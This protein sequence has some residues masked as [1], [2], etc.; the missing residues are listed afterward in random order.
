MSYD[1]FLKP[2][3]GHFDWAQFIKALQARRHYVVEDS[4]AFYQN[5]DT[6]VYYCFEHRG[7]G[8]EYPL[9]FNLNFF[10]PSIFALEAAPELTALVERFD[11]VVEDPQTKGMGTGEYDEEKMLAGWNYG[12]EF[13]CRTIPERSKLANF[14]AIAMPREKILRFWNWNLHRTAWQDEEPDRYVALAMFAVINDAPASFVV[15]PDAIPSIFPFVD[16]VVVLRDALAARQFFRRRPN[17]ALI[18]FAEAREIW[19]DIA[20][21]GEEKVVLDYS[22]PPNEMVKRVAALERFAGRIEAKPMA[23]VLERELLPQEAL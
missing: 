11:L 6:G 18:T 7:P 19:G 2:R 10:R 1:L 9:L 4:Q 16:Y 3:S 15:W 12:N 5:E 17:Q 23:S 8:E 21:A 13:A 14:N 20:R 22:T